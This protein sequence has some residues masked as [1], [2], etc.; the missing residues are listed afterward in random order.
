MPRL[1]KDGSGGAGG[2]WETLI[3]ALSH[4]LSRPNGIQRDPASVGPFVQRLGRE[5]G[6]VIDRDGLRKRTRGRGPTVPRARRRR[7]WPVSATLAVV[8]L[9]SGVT[10]LNSGG[11]RF[12]AAA[13]DVRDRPL[14]VTHR[15][16]VAQL[17]ATEGARRLVLHVGMKCMAALL[18][19]VLD[20][21]GVADAVLETFLVIKL[22]ALGPSLDRDTGAGVGDCAQQHRPGTC[23]GGSFPDVGKVL[24]AAMTSV[25][26]RSISWRVQV[27][28]NSFT[29]RS[30][31][32]TKKQNLGRDRITPG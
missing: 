22:T 28:A 24:P 1:Y 14:V 25:R 6:T 31:A 11:C 7:P 4:G 3:K 15:H 27:Q 18:R 8:L 30:S 26:T 23:R 9:P 16:F 5:F 12:R 17:A 20:E 13:A 21:V 2:R 29:S 19:E 32:F 10:A